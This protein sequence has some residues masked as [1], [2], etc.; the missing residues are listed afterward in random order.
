VG[1]AIFFL[2]FAAFLV[3]GVPVALALA[4]GCAAFLIATGN[5]DL[6]AALPRYMVAGLDQFVLLAIP[7]FVLAGSL[8]SQGGMTESIMRLS[9]ALV[10]R[11]PGGLSQVGIVASMIFGGAMGSAS[12][13]AAAIGSVLIPAMEKEGYPKPYAAAL[14]AVASM[15]GPIIPPSLAMIIYGAL[16]GTSI[17]ALFIAGIVPGIILGLALMAYA[18]WQAVRH[19]YAISEP[20]SRSEKL[21]A[22]VE[23]APAAMMPVVLL[24][25]IML[26]WFTATE[27]AAIAVLYTFLLPSVWRTLTIRVVYNALWETAF[28]TAGIMIIIG[29]SNM[30]AFVFAMEG[31]PQT[32]ASA[33]LSISSNIL[34]ILMMIN[35]VL[36]ILG[37]FLDLVAILI[38]TVPILTVLGKQIGIDPVHLGMIVVLN[39]VIGLV[40]PPVG[41]CL[42]VTSAISKLSIEEVAVASLPLL[43]ICIVVLM[44]VTYVP[45][46]SLFLPSLMRP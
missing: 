45:A 46:L 14:V 38:L 32:I 26:G 36:L 42:F 18:H 17:S 13:E 27:S 4:L 11:I 43:A 33:M 2:G 16:T 24:A 19:G 5:S 22:I 31:L 15:M 23:A 9:R 34:V 10:G 7:L 8:M 21:R 20:M 6:L 39:V 3:T 29:T 35:I 44:L 37:M 30:V 28:V 40:T 41:M 12:A 25:G 1:S